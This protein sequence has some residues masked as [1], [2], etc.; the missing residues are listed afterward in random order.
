[1]TAPSF[2]LGSSN[3]TQTHP[4]KSVEIRGASAAAGREARRSPCAGG[5]MASPFPKTKPGTERPAPPRPPS[6]PKPRAPARSGDVTWH[7]EETAR[8]GQ[9]G[10]LRKVGKHGAGR[11]GDATLQSALGLRSLRKRRTKMVRRHRAHPAAWKQSLMKRQPEDEESAVVF[12][13]YVENA[14]WIRSRRGTSSGSRVRGRAAGS[15]TGRHRIGRGGIPKG[16]GGRGDQQQLWLCWREE[17]G[18]LGLKATLHTQEKGQPDPKAALRGKAAGMLAAPSSSA[19]ACCAHPAP[20]RERVSGLQARGCVL[21]L[22]REPS[23]GAAEERAPR[24]CRSVWC[25]M[26]FS[27]LLTLE[28]AGAAVGDKAA[29]CCSRCSIS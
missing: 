25:R 29:C 12:G 27:C 18:C 21:R 2:Y 1:M 20:N 19:S 17:M 5:N 8:H 10:C 23:A 11:G 22:G 4:P 9:L 6:S 28:T 14:V 13:R 3:L 16:R 24:T 26:M 7:A 15:P